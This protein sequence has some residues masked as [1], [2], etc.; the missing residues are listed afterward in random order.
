[1]YFHTSIECHPIYFR[2]T[3]M[4]DPRENSL[5]EDVL[6]NFPV[7]IRTLPYNLLNSMLIRDVLQT[8]FL[9]DVTLF[10]WAMYYVH[11]SE[12]GKFINSADL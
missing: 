5:D 9:P 7:A 2:H 12:Y 3:K 10:T 6:A 11:F 4:N 8:P 1:M